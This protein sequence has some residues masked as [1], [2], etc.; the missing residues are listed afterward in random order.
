M[1]KLFNLFI[2]LIS[3]GDAVSTKRVAFLMGVVS[4]IVWLSA[5]LHSDGMTGN[6]IMA[7]QTFIGAV[8]VSYVGG[9]IV[10]NKSAEVSKTFD[11]KKESE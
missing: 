6:W 10:E 11:K 8:V 2:S 7:F 5:S 3:N 9:F 4:S 1:M